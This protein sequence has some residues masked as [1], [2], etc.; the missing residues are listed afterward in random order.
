MK[1]VLEAICKIEEYTDSLTKEEFLKSH[2]IQDAVLRRLEI[3]G[4]A[5]K[6]IPSEVRNIYSDIP[7]KQM[8]GMRDVLIHDYFGV[9]LER[10]WLTVKK[11]LP[12]VKPKINAVLKD[13]SDVSEL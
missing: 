5:V 10:V 7:W 4:E 11:D 12:K 6:N 3:I 8:A 1:D 2:L 9:N 13:L